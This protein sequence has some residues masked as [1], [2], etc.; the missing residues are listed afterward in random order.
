MYNMAGKCNC[1]MVF[2]LNRS[3]LLRRC[4]FTFASSCKCGFDNNF[5]SWF[6]FG[7]GRYNV[8]DHCSGWW[9]GRG[10]YWITRS[11]LLWLRFIC[12]EKSNF[13]KRRGS[14][15]TP[16]RFVTSLA[17]CWQARLITIDSIRWPEAT[18]GT[19][20]K[21]NESYR[22]TGRIADC[23]HQTL[24]HSVITIAMRLSEWGIIA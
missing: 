14:N 7:Y 19:N 5:G 23:T 13:F 10:S 24:V 1:V 11:L 4:F 20:V 17:A 16:S 8:F 12:S 2:V 18:D 6:H 15:K 21:I 22:H 9:M 3:D